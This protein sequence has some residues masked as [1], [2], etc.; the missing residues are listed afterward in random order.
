MLCWN[1]ERVTTMLRPDRQDSDQQLIFIDEARAF[2]AS[3]N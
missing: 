2:I 3:G 1:E